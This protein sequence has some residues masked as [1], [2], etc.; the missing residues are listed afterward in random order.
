[1]Y[2]LRPPGSA[3]MGAFEKHSMSR[4]VTAMSCLATDITSVGYISRTSQ[5]KSVTRGSFP[6]VTPSDGGPRKIFASANTS[7]ASV[8]MSGSKTSGAW[9]TCSLASVRSGNSM[10]ARFSTTTT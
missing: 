4:T 3:S 5:P 1:M 2:L 7:V 8:A 6:Q 10:Y 9:Y